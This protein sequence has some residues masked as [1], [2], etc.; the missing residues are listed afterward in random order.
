ME[1]LV[2]LAGAAFALWMILVTRVPADDRHHFGHGKAEYFSSAFEGMLIFVAAL[3]I[4]ATAVPRLI[5][6]QPLESI[7]WASLF[8]C[9]ARRST[10]PSHW[11]CEKQASTS[12]PS[13]SEPIRST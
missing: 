11:F 5:T 12:I 2:N 9:S 4:I 10:S 13:H 6:P 3:A 1:S 7:G 8:R